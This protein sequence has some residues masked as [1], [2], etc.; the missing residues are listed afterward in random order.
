MCPCGASLVVLVFGA[1]HPAVSPD[2]ADVVAHGGGE[3]E[4][5]DPVGRADL[6]D[7]A[8]IVGAAKLVA[9][10]GLVAIERDKLVA[11][12]GPGLFRRR[13]LRVPRPP[14]LEASH[15]RSLRV[16]SG[17]QA[18]QQGFQFWIANDTHGLLAPVAGTLIS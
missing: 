6:D 13:R 16:A 18:G 4:R 7:L 8:R 3:I 1:H 11:E 2:S 10:L 9:E 14:R 12:K 17:M 15:R 5:R